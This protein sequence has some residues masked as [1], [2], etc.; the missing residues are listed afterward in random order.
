MDHF[1]NWLSK[2]MK[3]EDI[4][5]WFKANNL[6]PELTDLFSDFCFSFYFLLKNTYLGDINLKNK[7]TNIGLSYE[8]KINH[9]KWCWDK[10]IHNFKKENIEFNFTKQ[11][12]EYFQSFFF[13]VFYDNNTEEMRVAL[14]DFLK[15]LFN[16]KKPMSKSD[17]E[18]FTDVYKT[19]ERSLKI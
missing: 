1:F 2:P 6:M 9:Y 7:E 13:E 16:T 14:E 12:Y 19:L 17:L 15:Q 5:T 4:D 18:M 3:T 10:T 11:D 8:D